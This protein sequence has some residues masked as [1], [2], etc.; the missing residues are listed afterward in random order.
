MLS[1]ASWIDQQASGTVK[2]KSHTYYFNSMLWKETTV[3]FSFFRKG[4]YLHLGGTYIQ[5]HTH[6]SDLFE[7]V[8]DNHI[9]VGIKK[10][11]KTQ[12]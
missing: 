2:N 4:T 8:F 6:C 5:L 10:K 9:I 3:L 7:P 1:K 12:Q 11:M